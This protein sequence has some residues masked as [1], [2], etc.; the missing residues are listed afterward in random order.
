MSN[1]L[2]RILD[3]AVLIG[4]LATIPLI[5]FAEESPAASWV[6]VAD[7]AIWSVFLLEYT[8][9]V[10]FRSQRILYVK[11]NPLNL[12]V[13]VLSYPQLPM[14]FGLVRLARLARVLRLLRLVSVTARAVKAL[15]TIFWRRGVVTVVLIS[16]LVIVAGGTGLRLIEPQTVRGG[17]VDGIWWAIVTASTIGYGDIAP[18]TLWG[19]VIAVMLMLS[20]IGLISTL[21]ASITAYFLGQEDDTALTELRERTA[22]MERLLDLLVAERVTELSKVASAPPKNEHVKSAAGNGT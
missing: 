17:F 20:G 19:R 3:T 11:R 1:R 9:T 22:R 18:N 4:A 7:W 8:I 5:V 16:G 12:V 6:Q 10:V 14:L 2:V 15:R 13:V 21:A